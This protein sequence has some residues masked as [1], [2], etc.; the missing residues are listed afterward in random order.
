MSLKTESITNNLIKKSH[1]HIELLIICAS[2]VIL[3]SFH[4]DMPSNEFKRGSNNL[5]N[6]RTES[7]L[8][9]HLVEHSCF[10]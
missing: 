5:T 8:S 7:C 4:L 2:E 1:L 3:Q 9:I 6:A 10:R